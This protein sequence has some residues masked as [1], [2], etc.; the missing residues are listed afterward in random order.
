M[1]NRLP[2]VLSITALVVALMGWTGVANAVQTVFAQN[3]AKLGG[4]APSKKAKKNTVVVRGASGRIDAKSI[5]AQAKGAKGARGPAGPAGPGGPA[6]PA[7]PQGPPGAAGGANGPAG[8]DLT[9]TYPNPT[10]GDLSAR[11]LSVQGIDASTNLAGAVA[12]KATAGATANDGVQAT[13]ASGTG[14]ALQGVT[15]GGAAFGV[16]AITSGGGT[17]MVSSS[18]PGSAIG[19]SNGSA[20]NATV[21]ANNSTAGGAAGRFT[22]TNALVVRPAGT[23]AT[24]LTAD[25]TG[26]IN[27]DGNASNDASNAIFASSDDTNNSAVITANSLPSPT[28]DAF[29]C[30]AIETSGFLDVNGNARVTGTL[31]KGAGSFE[32]D[33]PLDP[34]HYYLRH[35]F[36]ES[37]DM[38]NVYDG[39]VRT[40]ASRKATVTLPDWFGALNRDFRYQ[41]TIVGPTFAQAIVSKEIPNGGNRFEVKTDRPNVK[42]S[43]QVTGIRKDAFANAHRIKVVERKTGEAS[44][45]YLHPELFGHAGARPLGLDLPR[46]HTLKNPLR[47]E[48][49]LFALIQK[50]AAQAKREARR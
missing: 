24:G 17:G 36:V 20:T 19:A 47:T 8:G 5:P 38:K 27:G 45:H 18:G 6:G 21:T 44:E 14:D 28:C 25:M 50:K 31:T 35:S 22:G 33:H 2:T 10:I 12:L 3:A 4:F 40:G 34:A 13:T 11:R 46:V 23:S 15:S 16:F 26:D 9:G 37:P 29:T 49:Q 7:G 42:V 1:K 41:L 30:E 48:A 32:I 43:W 39:I